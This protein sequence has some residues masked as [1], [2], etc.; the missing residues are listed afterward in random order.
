MLVDSRT[1]AD[2]LSRIPR[3]S[4]DESLPGCT[5]SGLNRIPRITIFESIIQI[6][7]EEDI[8]DPGL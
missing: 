6:S 5:D 7:I 4:L 1:Y 3:K 2:V 8:S